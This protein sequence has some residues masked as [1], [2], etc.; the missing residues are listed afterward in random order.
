MALPVCLCGSVWFRES[1]AVGCVFSPFWRGE[2]GPQNDREIGRNEKCLA[3]RLLQISWPIRGGHYCSSGHAMRCAH[4]CRIKCHLRS[5]REKQNPRRSW[6]WSPQVVSYAKL[7]AARHDEEEEGNSPRAKEPGSVASSSEKPVLVGE[8]GMEIGRSLSS[9]GA[10]RR[11]AV[12]LAKPQFPCKVE[13]SWGWLVLI[14]TRHTPSQTVQTLRGLLTH[15]GSLGL[16]SPRCWAGPFNPL[17]L[18]AVD[19]GAPRSID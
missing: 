2:G 13:P 16:S 17:D 3:S 5:W 10:K 1:V 9:R 12:S 4:P 19:E 7:P 15:W 11:C 18:W 8:E 14:I 6:T